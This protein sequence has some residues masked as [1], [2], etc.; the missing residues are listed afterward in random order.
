MRGALEASFLLFKGFTRGNLL[1]RRERPVWRLS[2]VP[3]RR[4]DKELTDSLHQ[5]PI[6]INRIPL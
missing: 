6:A 1:Q 4:E 3:D 2:T 5:E